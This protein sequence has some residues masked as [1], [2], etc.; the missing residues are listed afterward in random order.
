M[1]LRRC[2]PRAASF[3][4]PWLCPLPLP[5]CSA[6]QGPNW[7]WRPSRAIQRLAHEFIDAGGV[8]GCI[9]RGD[10]RRRRGACV[11]S[12]CSSISDSCIPHPSACCRGRHCVWAQQP[13]H[14]GR[15]GVPPAAHH[16]WGRWGGA[17]RGSALLGRGQAA[18]AAGLLSCWRRNRCSLHARR[19]PASPRR[20][21]RYRR[22]CR[23]L[24]LGRRVPERPVLHLLLPRRRGAPRLAGA[25]AH[26]HHPYLPGTLPMPRVLCRCGQR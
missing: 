12:A 19:K 16:L 5:C 15:R 9:R 10:G 21:S 3:A 20:L 7:K 22:L 26:P 1:C 17:G 4:P 11:S 18:V 23:R 13:P 24:S 8:A 2:Q 25:G 14:P 6:L